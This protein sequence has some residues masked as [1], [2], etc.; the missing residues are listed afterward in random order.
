MPVR[1]E[2]TPTLPGLSPVCGKAIVARFDGARMSSDGGLLAL[3]E[4]E[5]RLA[6]ASRLAACIADPRA[7]ARVRHQPDEII[8]TR[9]L[10]IAAGYE[11]GND[12]D[13]L[14]G[15]PM[16]KLAMG[17]LPDDADLCSQPTISRLENLPDARALL[18]M[19][20][21]M[22]DHYCQSFRQ[23][24]RR[25]TLDIDDTFDA[26]HG[27][28]QLRLFNAHYDEY[29]FQ[30]IVVFDD[31]G[32]M[33]AAVLRPASRPTGRQIV[34]WLQRLITALR[35]N[36]P[37]VEIMLRADSHYCTP[38]VLRFCRARRLDY[39][40]GVAPIATLRAH[41]L[42]LEEST[43]ARAAAHADGSKLRRFKE[44]YD[45]AGSWDRV[46]RIIARVEAGPQGTDTRFVVTSLASL[47]GRTIYQDI[48]CARGQAENH[49]KA[50]KTHLAA[51]R[52]SCSRA[53]ANQ[54]RLFL[55]VGAYWLMWSLRTLMPRRSR[56]RVAQFDTLRLRL[57]KLAV[58]IEVLKTQVR[59]HLPRAMP[60]QAIFTL[61]LTRMPRLSL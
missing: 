8:R 27:G 44:F 47:S 5:Q 39:A 22:V 51:D 28:Q 54:M 13:R 12:A 32:R 38:E 16:F 36:W 48:Y 59:L 21:A 31:A 25:I 42:K 45:G 56:W 35:G 29:G 57:I 14:R 37:R 30:P 3:R 19:G 23:V 1:V 53:G 15:D 52:T 17:R 4:V 33:I 20:R 10:M 43:A 7:P 58:R 18:R 9:M 11:D 61:L 2:S 6:I 46:E 49:I 24:P 55:H 34:R 41:V 26:V 60:D 50:W 40:L